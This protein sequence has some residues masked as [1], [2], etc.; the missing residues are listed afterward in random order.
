VNVEVNSLHI[1]KI[2]INNLVC[3]VCIVRIDFLIEKS[4][5]RFSGR[6]VTCFLTDSDSDLQR[7]ASCYIYISKGVLLRNLLFFKSIHN[8][9]FVK[10][11]IR[12]FF[13]SCP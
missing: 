3:Y 4:D 7:Y 6:L 12:C 13:S 5:P 1:K 2:S 8:T 10:R 11:S 9:V